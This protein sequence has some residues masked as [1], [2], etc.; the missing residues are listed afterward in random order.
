MEAFTFIETT[1]W[2]LI[3]R[4]VLHYDAEGKY[5]F[6]QFQTFPGWQ[7]GPF[8]PDK[9]PNSF[10]ELLRTKFEQMKSFVCFIKT[11]RLFRVL[12]LRVFRWRYP[13]MQLCL[14][15]RIS[16]KSHHPCGMCI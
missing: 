16:N 13:Q 3:Q 14:G 2:D 11:K 8:F 5:L 10:V 1:V 7:S 6:V 12:M 4:V 15:F 9:T